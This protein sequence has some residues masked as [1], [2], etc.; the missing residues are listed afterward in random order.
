METFLSTSISIGF[1]QHPDPHNAIS[2]ACMM[3][4]NQLNTADTDLV[5]IFASPQYIVPET[6]S[7]I[8][9]ILKPK[10]LVGSSTGRIIL[11]N[12]VANLGIAIVGIN[13]DDM[14]F[15]VSAIS[16][17]DA[18]NMYSTGFDLARKA[19]QDLNSSHREV[20]IIFSEGIE[21]NS[22]QF[23]RGVKEALG[24]GFPVLGAIS[25]DDFKYKRLS[26][27]FQDQIL[28][29]SVVG[30]LLGGAFNLALGCKHSFKPLGKPRTITKVDGCIVRT[31]DNEPA[32]EIYKHFL[33]SD[34]EGLKN[35]T[36]NSSA[37][38]YPLGFYLEESRQYLLRNIIDILEDGSI[39]CHEGIPQGAEVH[40]MISNNESCRNSA[41]E[42]AELV[43]ASLA[44]KP[45]KLVLVFESLARHRILGRNTSSEI[46]AIKDVLGKTTPIVGMCSYG[47]IGPFETLSNIKNIYLHN[48]SILIV[49]IS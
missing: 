46:Q 32:V 34:A 1:S 20:F 49:G 16:G 42:A 48:E 47:E 24:G 29:N 35:F 23:I 38:M 6:Q 41:I 4:K 26:Q 15:G 39:V 11:S 40:L 18:Q 37:A 33:G 2:Q 27:F 5:I 3:V 21:K 25:S 14:R 43:K 28:H 12:G 17:I 31:I 30:L 9:R 36:L 45:A 8:S 13:S 10:H 7:V 22:S 44:D 19:A